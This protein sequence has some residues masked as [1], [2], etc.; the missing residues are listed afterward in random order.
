MK[1]NDFGFS[2]VFG[3]RGGEGE[4]GAYATTMMMFQREAT[5]AFP[6]CFFF[7]LFSSL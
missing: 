6:F 4:G 1:L 2:V 3:G 7:P 5:F